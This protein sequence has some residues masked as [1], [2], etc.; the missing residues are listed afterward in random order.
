[1]F[2]KGRTLINLVSVSQHLSSGI[3]TLVFLST[4]SQEFTIEKQTN[5]T[6]LCFQLLNGRT[7]EFFQKLSLQ[8][9]FGTSKRTTVTKLTW[10]SDVR[11]ARILVQANLIVAEMLVV[12]EGRVAHKRLDTFLKRLTTAKY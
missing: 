3:N 1:M 2:N 5:S 6:S 4:M 7:S 11:C 12:M 10:S 9:K 8:K